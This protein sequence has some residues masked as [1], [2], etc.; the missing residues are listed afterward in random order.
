MQRLDMYLFDKGL[1]SSRTKAKELIS[2][3]KVTVDG[4]VVT[5]P[6]CS[7]GDDSCIDI[8]QT[9][10]YVGRGALKL[11]KAFDIFHL[12]VKDK[13]CADI[14]AST[15]GF[16]Q[17]LLEN[18]A[19]FVYAVDVGHGQ[20]ANKLSSDDRV[21]NCEGV[22]IR[23]IEPD[24][25]DNKVEFMCCDLSFISL[26]LTVPAMISALTDGGELVTLIKP[27]FEAGREAL[28]KKGIVTDRKK[29]IEVLN[30][31]TAFFDGSG[32]SIIGLDYS[33][34]RGGDGNIEYLAYMKKSQ[35]ASAWI[36]TR[37]IVFNAFENSK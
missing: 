28:N 9:D 3:G 15:G 19:K 20:L 18:G 27:Q 37:K 31:L 22:N 30:M 25:F 1:A 33:P 13:V 29:H 35:E 11:K 34:V 5:K 2:Q 14:G 36:D 10:N 32:M 16:T 23:Y 4:L 17:V 6:S 8:F 12:N 7:V 21:K 24:F 26:T